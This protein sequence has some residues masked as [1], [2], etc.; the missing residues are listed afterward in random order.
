MTPDNL[1]QSYEKAISSQNWARVEPLMHNGVCVTFSTGTF[2]GID[3]V[4]TVFEKNFKLIK[5]ED[6][7]ISNVHWA[8][9]ND[10]QAVCLYDF[11]W[12]GLINSE[13]CSGGGRGTSVLVKIGNEWKIITEHLGPHPQ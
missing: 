7:K 9:S 13:P 5:D 4:K 1:L 3:S 12:T 2:K 10:I 6:Y 11:T 8:L